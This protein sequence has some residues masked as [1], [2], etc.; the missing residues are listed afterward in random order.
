[1]RAETRC[2]G[3]GGKGQKFLILAKVHF[4]IILTIDIDYNFKRKV[5]TNLSV[6]LK[7]AI[8]QRMTDIGPTELVPVVHKSDIS[9]DLFESG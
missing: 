4:R 6:T 9:D 1:M 5:N 8:V 7:I 2:C 3:Y